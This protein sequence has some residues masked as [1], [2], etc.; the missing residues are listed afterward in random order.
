MHRRLACL[1]FIASIAPSAICQTRVLDDF[2]DITG[3]KAVVSEGARL[4]L[5]CP[6]V[7]LERALVMDFDLSGVHGYVV[8]EK[9][10][11]FDLPADYRFTFDLRGE[12]PPN[13]FEFKLTDGHGNVHWLKRLN[14]GFPLVWTKQRI[15]TRQISFAW[16][17]EGVAAAQ[18]QFR[19]WE[20]ERGQRSEC[21]TLILDEQLQAE[22]QVLQQGFHGLS[23][24]FRLDAALRS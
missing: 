6:T 12:A 10:F 1:T 15:C 16:G 7:K 24:S 3:W 4:T 13:N 19:L 5:G 21:E 22:P 18:E 23:R 2:E 8:A 20:Q 9:D 14:V 17:P 11:S